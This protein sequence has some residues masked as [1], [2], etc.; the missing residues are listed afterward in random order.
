MDDETV[1]R[2]NRDDLIR[3]ATVLVGRADA[4]EVVSIVVLRV[5]AKLR[6]HEPFGT[7][8]FTLVCARGGWVRTV[9]RLHRPAWMRP[10]G[11]DG[12][13]VD[14]SRADESLRTRVLSVSGR[15]R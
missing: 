12:W 8:P 5:L 13:H 4:E 11:L 15:P 6:I 1:Y 3:Y 14:V 2:K 7:T 9:T 10:C